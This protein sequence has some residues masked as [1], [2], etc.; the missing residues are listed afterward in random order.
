MYINLET[1]G[2]GLHGGAWVRKRRGE[3]ELAQGMGY[4]K[5]SEHERWE[6]FGSSLAGAVLIWEQEWEQRMSGYHAGLGKKCFHMDQGRAERSLYEDFALTCTDGRVV[7]GKGSNG[8]GRFERP[9]RW[10][11]VWLCVY[12]KLCSWRYTSDTRAGMWI[13]T[14]TLFHF[15]V[16]L[17][18]VI[19]GFVASF[20]EFSRW[21][22]SSVL[23]LIFYYWD[24]F[25]YYISFFA[26]VSLQTLPIYLCFSLLNSC[27]LIF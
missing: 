18:W 21:Q 10:T 23:H 8:T 26:L 14:L 4:S 2:L 5:K 9:K 1:E 27:P 19:V 11:R 15:K 17:L 3:Q 25:F 20:E 22:L 7:H 12:H 6:C 16:L 13:L 24:F